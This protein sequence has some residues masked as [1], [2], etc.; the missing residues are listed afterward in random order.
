FLLYVH[1]STLGEEEREIVRVAVCERLAKTWQGLRI[2]RAFIQGLGMDLPTELVA[3][4][5]TA[6]RLTAIMATATGI[7]GNPRLVK[8]FLN[9]LSVRMAV[10]KNQGVF[11]DEAALA[12][13]L[14]F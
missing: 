13:L 1:N 9:A 6:D 4:L 10:A 5:D 3:Q 12:K 8:R 14:L 2:D 7:A 11:V